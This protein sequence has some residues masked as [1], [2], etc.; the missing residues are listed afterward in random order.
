MSV[1][2]EVIA[3]LGGVIAQQLR[4]V[5]GKELGPDDVLGTAVFS[6]AAVLM[7]DGDSA[8]RSALAEAYED[9]QALA[10]LHTELQ[11]PG[12]SPLGAIAAVVQQHVPKDGSPNRQRRVRRVKSLS[13]VALLLGH[14][15]CTQ[16]RRAT[17][18]PKSPKTEEWFISRM[19]RQPSVEELRQVNCG[20][21]GEP[22]HATCGVCPDC[23]MPFLHC[24]CV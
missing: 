21:T 7:K 2:S 16:C 3:S 6:V 4:E 13:D 20:C 14:K 17:A 19:G 10:D 8:F 1:K 18:R 15:D 11:K 12:A 23:D 22:N 5:L 9:F 24:T